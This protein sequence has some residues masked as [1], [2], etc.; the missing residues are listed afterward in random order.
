M[1]AK[2]CSNCAAP[3]KPGLADAASI[4]APQGD[5]AEPET[6]FDAPDGERRRVTVLFCDIVSSTEIAA[7]LDP[8]EW[9]A[10]AA[11]YQRTAAA[12]A[13]KSAGM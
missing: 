8:E 2:F 13:T 1:H 6:A 5:A 7:R 4:Q 9:H 12:A 3:L 11:Q 10:I